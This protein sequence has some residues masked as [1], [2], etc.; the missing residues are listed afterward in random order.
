MSYLLKKICKWSCAV[1]TH[2]AQGSAIF[3]C[4]G[5]TLQGE[6]DCFLLNYYYFLISSS[7]FN[8][9]LTGYFVIGS[10]LAQGGTSLPLEVRCYQ[11]RGLIPSSQDLIHLFLSRLC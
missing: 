5:E 11:V 6:K 3:G 7:V 1:P 8:E 4:V 9:W 2:V 10:R